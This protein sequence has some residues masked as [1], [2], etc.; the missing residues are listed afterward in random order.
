MVVIEHHL[1]VIGQADWI[2]DLGPDGGKNG[3][4]IIFTGTLEQLVRAS[5]SLTGEYL[6]QYQSAWECSRVQ[7]HQNL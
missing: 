4:E 7:D 5:G 6:R 2:I 1:A 3:G